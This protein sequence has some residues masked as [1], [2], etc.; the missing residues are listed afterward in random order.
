MRKTFSYLVAAVIGLLPLYG[1]ASPSAAQTRPAF[2]EEQRKEIERIV[3]DYITEKD[4]EILETGLKNLQARKQSEADAKTKEKVVSE[5]DKVFNDPST[6]MAGNP[7]GKIAIAWFYDYQ[8]GYCKVSDEALNR[9]LKEEKDVKVV[10]KNFPVL[11]NTSVEAARAV[12]ASM[13][14]NKFMAFH[15]ALMTKK[16][17]LTSDVIYQTAKQAGLDVEKLKKDMEDK[18][19]NEALFNVMKLGQD[20]GIQ[21]T[22]FFVIGETYFPGV[23][24]YEQ[25]KKA[26]T[27]V[28]K[29]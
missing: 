8:C 11:G 7:N 20:L 4:P 14:Q 3:K 6:P 25:L 18:Q 19:G 5:K 22:P 12:L 2:T 10:Y 1:I 28:R 27:E 26:I 9:I 21:G 17:H 23:M 13:K 29:K 16:E 24:Q 15:N